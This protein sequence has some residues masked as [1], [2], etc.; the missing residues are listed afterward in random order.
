MNKPLLLALLSVSC[1]SF[2]HAADPATRPAA[3]TRPAGKQATFDDKGVKFTYPAD[4]EV[5]SDVAASEIV[6]ALGKETAPTASTCMFNIM[7]ADVPQDM[8]V[9]QAAD[10]GV[11]GVQQMLTDF[12]LIEKKPIKLAGKPGV[13]LVYEG[14]SGDVAMRTLQALTIVSGKIYI[15]TWENKPPESFDHYL[16]ACEKTL[17]SFQ[18]TQSK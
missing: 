18:L 15:L 12:K 13:R 16:P 10:M 6:R 5:K 17:K 14:K 4:W 3:T 2:V 9:D 8:T 7:S 11:K 1:C